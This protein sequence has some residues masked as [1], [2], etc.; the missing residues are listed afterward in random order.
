MEMN[1]DIAS[2]FWSHETQAKKIADSYPNPV[3]PET[4]LLSWSI[5]D[6][7]RIYCYIFTNFV[8]VYTI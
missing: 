4:F 8:L 2:L 6:D 3:N 5:M 1:K 7:I